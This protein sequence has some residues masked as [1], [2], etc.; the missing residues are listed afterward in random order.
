RS[1]RRSAPRRTS[2]SS[3]S[4]GNAAIV[5]TKLC[6]TSPHLPTV[7][8]FHSLWTLNQFVRGSR[9]TSEGLC[10]GGTRG[11][12]LRF[13]PL[14]RIRHGELVAAGK[15]LQFAPL[16]RHG[17]GRSGASAHAVIG[18]GG[19]GVVVA[20]VVDEYAAF[21]LCLA[22]RGDVGLRLTFSHL[23]SDGLGERLD[24]G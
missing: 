4:A 22:H 23:L 5:A 11:F 3:V 20:Q 2:G 24:L 15:F 1:G 13:D 8:H 12:F 19:R 17:D 6:W 9:A 14:E 7:L 21:P 10:S 16:E 18:D